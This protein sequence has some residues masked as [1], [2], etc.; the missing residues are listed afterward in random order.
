VLAQR[1]GLTP[2]M[3]PPEEIKNLIREHGG[4]VPE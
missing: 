2:S 1:R 4:I 3:V